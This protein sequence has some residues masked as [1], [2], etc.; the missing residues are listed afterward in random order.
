MERLSQEGCWFEF[1]NGLMSMSLD[2]AAA[3]DDF[4][5]GNIF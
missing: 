2:S 3:C 4:G 5:D 1:G